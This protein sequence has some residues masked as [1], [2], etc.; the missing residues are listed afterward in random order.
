MA[1]ASETVNYDLTATDGHARFLFGGLSPWPF[2]FPSPNPSGSLLSTSPS[3]PGSHI[4]IKHTHT[5]VKADAFPEV[6]ANVDA[7]T[8]RKGRRRRPV[9]FFHFFPKIEK[10]NANIEREKE[11]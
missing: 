4:K 8:H 3:L 11:K 6:R 9:N 5:L 2:F 1:V 10:C 7:R